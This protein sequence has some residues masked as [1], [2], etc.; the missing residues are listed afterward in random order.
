MGGLLSSK[1][2]SA[3]EEM[4]KAVGWAM[5]SALSTDEPVLT[6]MSLAY[7]SSSAFTKWLGHPLVHILLKCKRPTSGNDTL[8]TLLKPADFWLEDETVY[9]ARN[10]DVAQ[11]M[12]VVLVANRQG[13][14]EYC[15]SESLDVLR[16]SLASLEGIEFA[17]PMEGSFPEGGASMRSYARHKPRFRM[18]KLFPSK[19]VCRGEAEQGPFGASEV[20]RQDLSKAELALFNFP[21]MHNR[22][23]DPKSYSYSDG[24]AVKKGSEPIKSSKDRSESPGTITGT[25][26]VMA[27]SQRIAHIDPGGKDTTNTIVRAELVGVQARLQE[28]MKDELEADSTF[29]L[30]T[31]SQVPLYSIKKAITQPASSWLNAHEPLL[32][33]IVNRLKDLT[34]AGHHIH[35]GKVKAHMGVR[36]NIL[37][38][39]AAK[40][41]VTQ[42]IL[43][44]D[45]D[46]MVNSF[47]TQE[48]TDAQ[49]DTVCQVNSNAHE[50]DEWPVHPIPI[51]QRTDDRH[52]EEMEKLLIEGTWPDGDE[53]RADQSRRS[54]GNV[55][56]AAMDAQQSAGLR[57]TED[58]G[59][60]AR[61]LST[62]LSRALSRSCRL[63]YSNVQAVYVRLWRDVQPML[64]PEHSHLFWDRFSRGGKRLKT[65]TVRNALRLR[66]GAF[67]NAKLAMRFQKPYLGEPSDGNC[68]LCKQPDSGT[69]TLGACA[70][71]HMKGLYIERHN[72]AVAC[73]SKAFMEGKKGGC[74]TALMIDAGWHG[75]V[76]GIAAFERIP[77]QVLPSMPDAVLK[78]MRPDLLLFERLEGAGPLNLDSLE[79]ASERRMCKVHVV[80]VGFCMETAYMT[81]Y[82]E[83]HAQH[84]Q[85]ITHLREAGYA[86]VK[87]HLLIFGSTGG[88]FHLTA[89]HLKQLGISGPPGKTLLESLHFR[90]LKRLEQ[91][92]GTRRRLEHQSNEP[93]NR[94]RK[95]DE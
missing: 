66:Y 59:W 13:A 25:G 95:R 64:L 88:M 81:K 27:Q 84:H 85:L 87:L 53:R 12:L 15:N 68:P 89:Q 1:T 92:V 91:L 4:D 2:P 80:E 40:A 71:R 79:H 72:E 60:Q 74:L 41:V 21:R 51:C 93:D 38:D 26:L 52:L 36:G 86:D 50:H 39:A 62:S 94:K 10:K 56:P 30:L 24:P 82:Q 73:V 57:A 78:R 83:K 44:A 63:G 45:P 76:T 34:D 69:H 29:R 20:S 58:D 61:N 18:P 75:K 32:R 70:H 31:D 67:W 6:V 35:L 14:S 16:V 37:A 7:K 33:D 47:S 3:D 28:I 77:L 22:A 43:D 90:A 23:H 54:G 17:R 55:A 65:G 49:I 8:Y 9:K 5:A 19:P 42:K 11:A 46:N 48:L